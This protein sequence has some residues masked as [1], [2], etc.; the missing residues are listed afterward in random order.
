MT[1]AAARVVDYKL[2][3][4]LI[5]ID[6]IEHIEHKLSQ[7]Y[8]WVKTGHCARRHYVYLIKHITYET[9]FNNCCSTA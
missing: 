1:T 6:N 8:E 3:Q 2:D 5:K 4:M 7:V 9:V